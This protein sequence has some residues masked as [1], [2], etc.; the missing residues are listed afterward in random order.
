MTTAPTFRDDMAEQLQRA[1]WVALSMLIHAV[2]IVIVLL[3]PTQSVIAQPKALTML[4]PEEVIVIDELEPKEPDPVEPKE[5]DDPELKEIELTNEH[6]SVE[7]AE[8]FSEPMEEFTPQDYSHAV[9]FGPSRPLGPRGTGRA[10]LRKSNPPTVLAIESALDWLR[11]HQ[12]EDGRWDAD[13]FM[14]HDGEQP[15]D[16]PGS[17]VHDVGVTGLALLAFLGDGSDLRRGPH[18]DVVKKAVRWLRQQQDSETGLF[19]STSSAAFIYDHAIAALAMVEAYGLSDAQ[20]LRDD[21]QRGLDYLASHRNPYGVWR[22]QPQDGDNDTSVTGWCL[23]AYKRGRVFG[24]TVEDRAFTAC[25]GW[26][27]EVTDASTGHC[28]YT[29]RGE[30]SSRHPGDHAVR[31]PADNNESMTAVGLMSRFL[32]RQDPAQHPVMLAAA[33]RVLRAPPRW[34]DHGSI[35]HYTWYYAT[36]ALYQLGGARWKSWSK[37]LT[38]AVVKTQ[39]DDGTARGSWDPVGVWG[40][41]GGRVYSTAILALTLEAYYRYT[42]VIVR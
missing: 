11:R 8:D 15:C 25:A 34:D 1:P 29:R 3:I 32:L 31:F 27:D 26:F 28:G 13:G 7:A 38:D 17:A 39:R 18:R 24:L 10:K 6:Q 36:Y 20:I 40:E 2:A 42:R 21:A 41:D 30:L 23:M 33:D 14:K 16:G 37:K 22:Y 12:D 9:G 19:G 35:D 5:P 4:P